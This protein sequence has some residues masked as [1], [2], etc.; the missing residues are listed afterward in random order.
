MTSSHAPL[1]SALT[2]FYTLLADLHHYAPSAI[3]LPPPQTGHYP[4]ER[5]DTTAARENGFGPDAT[6]LIAQLPFLTGADY[7]IAYDTQALSYLD[8][9]GDDAFDF[10]RDP[11]YQE[12]TDLM[13]EHL[14][15]L[16]RGLMYG[17]ELIYD[18]RKCR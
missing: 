13:E 18:T 3:T 1:I 11:T 4:A 12:R 8:D 6:D 9:D 5:I 2:T 10:A 17:T 15:V 16:T 14:V 7:L